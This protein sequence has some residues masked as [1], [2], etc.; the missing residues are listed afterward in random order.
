MMA[1]W[2]SSS[3][4][5]YPHTQLP[6]RSESISNR[7]PHRHHQELPS[8][9]NSPATRTCSTFSTLS[10]LCFHQAD[11]QRLLDT[12]T[13]HPAPIKALQATKVTKLDLLSLADWFLHSY[14]KRKNLLTNLFF[15]FLVNMVFKRRFTILELKSKFIFSPPGKQSWI[16]GF[17]VCCTSH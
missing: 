9:H 11:T 12:S 6:F 2:Q 7:F 3:C 15:P 14:K 4:S 8:S 5:S 16:T 17:E 1:P 10:L 13:T